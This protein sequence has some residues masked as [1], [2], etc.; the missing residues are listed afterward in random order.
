MK[1]KIVL[2][3]TSILLVFLLS[4]FSSINFEKNSLLYYL[5]EN[6][7]TLKVDTV[8]LDSLQA[9]RNYTYKLFKKNAHASY[10]ATKFNGRKTAS[11]AKYYNNKY[12]AAHK[13][14]PFGTMLRITNERNKKKVIVTV[15]DRGPFVKGREIDL[16][17]SAYMA[18]TS[19]K[20]GGETMVT[21]EV[22]KKK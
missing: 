10:Y 22:M 14:F 7:D 4:S 1:F 17:R 19:N 2:I 18:I 5:S 9:D 11:G 3:V 13:K 21:I 6:Q 15:N 12:T 20:S 8:A 16:S